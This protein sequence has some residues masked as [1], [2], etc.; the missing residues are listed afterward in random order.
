[1]SCCTS[2]E[3]TDSTELCFVLSD[4]ISRFK[5]LLGACAYYLTLVELMSIANLRVII[6]TLVFVTL[7]F[8]LLFLYCLRFTIKPT[9]FCLCLVPPAGVIVL[10]SLDSLQLV[11]VLRH[12]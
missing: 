6:C 10:W 3:N 1:M 12:P 8:H 7:T 2:F 9:I 5:S 11:F 4:V